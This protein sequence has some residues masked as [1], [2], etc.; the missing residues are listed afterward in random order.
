MAKDF[1]DKRGEVLVALMNNQSDMRI[2][3][4]K[5]W[6][7]IPKDTA[8]KQWPPKWLAFYQ[9]RIFDDQAYSVN[10]FGCVTEIREATRQELLPDERDHPHWNRIYYQLLL[11]KVEP[12]PA[13]IPSRRWRRITFIPTTWQKFANAAEIN[14]LYS[15]TPPEEELWNELKAKQI[16]AEREYEI[17]IKK[18]T[19]RLDFAVTCELGD[20][21]VETDGDTYHAN[22]E[23]AAKD[24]LRNNAL[25]SAGW[26]VLRFTRR[27]VRERMSYCMEN[28]EETIS[29]LDGVKRV[30]QPPSLYYVTP[31]GATKRRAVYEERAEYNLD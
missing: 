13:P 24:N 9:T 27:Q 26:R 8:P 14:D 1:D 7:R 6:Y 30:D 16:T 15:G 11:E 5:K 23:R 17:M 22:P 20:I 28:I 19:Y 31:S 12:L 10:Y 29:K 4:E 18:K 2:L 25:A 3:S 21:D